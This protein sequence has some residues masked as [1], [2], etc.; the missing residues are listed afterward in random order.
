MV[1]NLIET[2]ALIIIGLGLFVL[3]GA[4]VL[5][6]RANRQH[7]ASLGYKRHGLVWQRPTRD[8]LAPWKGSE[9]GDEEGR[10]GSRRPSE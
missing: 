1:V 6:L 2:V 10:H 7:I 9:D 8:S 4:A 5:A 3:F